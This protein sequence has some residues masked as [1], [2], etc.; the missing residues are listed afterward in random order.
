MQIRIIVTAALMLLSLGTLA[1]GI[2]GIDYIQSE[3]DPSKKGFECTSLVSD[4][5]AYD[6]SAKWIA[7]NFFHHALFMT[8]N[9]EMDEGELTFEDDDRYSGSLKVALD[10]QTKTLKTLE[11][12]LAEKVLKSLGANSGHD[13]E[14]TYHVHC[15]L[16]GES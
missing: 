15:T 12:I 4:R 13:F 5:P 8:L 1:A 9:L 16:P 6:E 7:N 2:L 3:L 10:S 14:I 11:V